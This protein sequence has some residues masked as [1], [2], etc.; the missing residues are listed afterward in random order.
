MNISYK[1][2][3]I[4]LGI[5]IPIV[6]G[7]GIIAAA[8]PTVI[9]QPNSILPTSNDTYDL[10]TS[11]LEWKNV[12]TKNLTAS[13]TS[14][15]ATTTTGV[16]NGT[17][18]V[19]GFPFPKSGVG[20]QAAATFCGALHL[21]NL[22]SVVRLV[23]AEYD[24]SSA[25]SIPNGVCVVGDR[26]GTLVKSTTSSNVNVFQNSNQ[27]NGNANL[28]IHDMMID[29]GGDLKTAGAPS[30]V[31][32]IGVNQFDVEN[33]G[34][35]NVFADGIYMQATGSGINSA[36][37]T[38]RD[39]VISNIGRNGISGVGVSEITIDTVNCYG[40]N[41]FSAIGNGTLRCVDIEGNIDDDIKINNVTADGMK[42]QAVQVTNPSGGNNSS[43]RVTITNST[44][45]NLDDSRN[46]ASDN[47]WAF[48]IVDLGNSS[49]SQ[50]TLSNNHVYNYISGNIASKVWPYY[51][52]SV[53][54]V[55]MTGNSAQDSYGN[56]GGDCVHIIASNGT[57]TSNTF[58][59]CYNGIDIVSGSNNFLSGNS[60][61]NVRAGGKDIIDNGTNTI[62]IAASSTSRFLETQGDLLLNAWNNS[63]N[64]AIHN[65]N[66][67]MLFYDNYGSADTTLD[68][69]FHV[70]TSQTA[71]LDLLGNKVAH[72][73]GNVGIGTSS[74]PQA[75]SVNGQIYTTG[76]LLFGDGSLQTTAT[77]GAINSGT[78]GQIGF[79][80]A[81]GTTISGTSSIFVGTN[82]KVGIGYSGV[83]NS[84]ML[85][86][87]STTPG[88]FIGLW[89]QGSVSG[90]NL[91]FSTGRDSGEEYGIIRQGAALNQL[92]FRNNGRI[93]IGTTSPTQ[94]LEV[95]GLERITTAV[96]WLELNNNAGIQS[97]FGYT[98]TGSDFF[99]SGGIANSLTL[100]SSN[101]LQFGTNST[102]AVTILSSGNVGIGTTSPGNI[103]AIQ[104]NQFIAG[105]IT[106]TSTIAS[107][108]PYAS[109]T[110][111]TAVTASTT[112]LIVSSAGG[113]A[114]CATFSSNGTI[115]NIGATCGTDVFA[116]PWTVNTLNTW[117]TTTLSTTTSIWTLGVFFSSSTKAASQFPYATSTAFTTGTLFVTQSTNNYIGALQSSAGDA[118]LYVY[119]GTGEGTPPTTGGTVAQFGA[120]TGSGTSADVSII[121]GTAGSANILFGDKDSDSVGSI[122]WSNVTNKFNISGGNVG[123]GVSSPSQALDVNG[124]ANIQGD[125]IGK[126]GNVF[127]SLGD[128]Y[129]DA[130]SASNIHLRPNNG[131]EK[132]TILSGGSVGLSTTTPG[133][134]LSI[135]GNQF[136]AGNITS[137]STT[138]NIFPYA[139]STG[140]S[141]SY[142]SSTIDNVGTL[143]L[144]SPLAIASG[145]TNA[146]SQSANGVAYYDGSK[147]TSGSAVTWNG[148]DLS[149]TGD[150]LER[151]NDPNN[152]ISFLPQGGSG[153]R[154]WW[155]G[156]TRSGASLAP[157]GDFFI[158]DNT[159]GGTAR[160]VIDSSGNVGIGTT[161]PTTSLGVQYAYGQ[162]SGNIFAV[163]SSTASNGSTAAT[164]FNVTNTGTVYAPNTTTLGTTQT[165]YWC[166]DGNGQLIRDT[167]TCLVSALK[168]KRDIHNMDDSQALSAV[169]KMQPVN[170]Y[171]KDPLG[172]DAAHEQV[173]FIADYSKDIVPDLITHDSSGDIHGFNYEQYT[174]YLTGAIR[175]Q[176][177]EIKALGGGVKKSAAENWQW[178]LIAL[179]LVYVA[180]NEFEK[181]RK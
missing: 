117:S 54:P 146:T 175:A 112:N 32:I 50:A 27:T 101:N 121:A 144:N 18:Y 78:Q 102:V 155:V 25:I 71:A 100:R 105:N 1:K 12:F 56:A 70:T 7:F 164:F 63:G 107:I 169:L 181:R 161:T 91:T 14:T 104:G 170:Y 125:I 134:I 19:T 51:I 29:G 72:F 92:V 139:S 114:G 64:A 76:G 129:L 57:Y 36:T 106:S 126:S 24:T 116:F 13:G 174:A 33:L 113:T 90:G 148:S 145:G 99:S 83:N 74:P 23:T 156:A 122:N 171:E 151:R 108:F 94:N 46:V 179:L 6:F 162:T 26:Y 173:G 37:G 137:T 39:L 49:T 127:K 3:R 132:V 120:N 22:C 47:V 43:H 97:Y 34:I 73:Y 124:S 111:L 67:A 153:A 58:D 81:A 48:G 95:A 109:T 133:A 31:S 141:T 103:L 80:N 10:G 52:Q 166:Y 15:L 20:I 35:T 79:Y 177:E 98:T 176:Q 8:A 154:E 118:T 143:T 158:F 82:Q 16:L 115:S 88:D 44:A 84:D 157:Q 40:H 168:F 160:L 61:V 65:N 62:I 60:I 110:A 41:Y 42:A 131:T 38:I 149:T 150:I 53:N 9:K 152:L 30:A 85:L 5:V 140:I 163:A 123:I 55:I 159:A 178:A 59:D 75:L 77:V 147:I 17:I 128:L 167:I 87:S 165:G 69:R 135:Q 86:V 11:T 68:Y 180:Y 138:A 89:D 142:A 45:K 172:P 93:G 130:A 66:G 119:R 96:P 4:I 21:L 2:T 28:C 136:I